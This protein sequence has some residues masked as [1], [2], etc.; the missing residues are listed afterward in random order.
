MSAKEITARAKPAIVRIEVEGH[1]GSSGIGTGF[2][3]ADNGRIATNLHVIVQAK[4]ARVVLLDGTKFPVN[5]V[6]AIDE[7]R[8]L[9]IIGISTQRRVPV[10]RLGDSDDVAAGDAVIAI[11]NPQGFDYTVSDGLISSVRRATDLTLL[12]ISAPISQGSSG[13]PLFNEYGEVIGVATLLARNG[14]NL[15]FAVP[16]NYLRPMMRQQSE[17]ASFEAFSQV[18]ARSFDD[19]GSESE[20]ADTPRIVRRVPNHDLSFLDGCTDADLTLAV[21]QILAAIRKGAPI[22]NSGDHEACFRI[23]EGTSLR[24]EREASDCRGVRDALGQG[25][26]RAETLETYTE[27]AWAMRDAFDGL[28]SVVERKLRAEGRELPA[29]E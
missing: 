24:L 15:N 18:T 14:Q 4:V 1:D 3:V 28:L 11:G 19:D 29:P 12:Q 13:G 21:G 16:A 17:A 8:D 20:G 26:L 2:F 6:F 22:Y 5:S 10:L 23:Y 25:L 27:K 7:E 9:A